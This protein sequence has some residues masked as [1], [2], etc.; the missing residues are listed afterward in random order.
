M[1]KVHLQKAAEA[2][3][4]NSFSIAIELYETALKEAPDCFGEWDAWGY[5]Q[6]LKQL[7]Q[8]E[9][10]LEVCR[11]YYTRHENFE[12]LRSL[13]AWCI[14]FTQISST[15]APA[16]TENR[17]KALQAINRLCPQGK[18]YS[19]APLAIFKW[20][21]N[22][23]AGPNIPWTEIKEWLD[24][25][26]PKLL[27]T[28]CYQMQGKGKLIELASELEEWYSWQSK[29]LLQLGKWEEGV[30]LCR[31]AKE[32]I[33]KWH[34][35]NHVWFDRREA[36]ALS[37]SGK[38]DDAKKLL[39]KALAQKRE[40]FMLADMAEL[41][42]DNSLK[43][44]FYGAACRA[45]GEWKSKVGLLL[46]IAQWLAQKGEPKA[47]ELHAQA[48]NCIR[49]KEGWPLS[50]SVLLLAGENWVPEQD[51]SKT[52][53]AILEKLKEIW[54]TWEVAA[55]ML[56]GKIREILPNGKA[57]FIAEGKRTFYFQLKNCQMPGHE[58][59][60]GRNVKFELV[61]GFDKK[62]NIISKNATNIRKA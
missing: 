54:Q 29:C 33:Q 51:T 38:K 3:K 14:Y 11:K 60:V 56:E 20:V 31:E 18:P 47:A 62:K 57:E 15:E 37:K 9:K 17:R 26:D 30:A 7:K 59:T 61:D 52:L 41:E 24:K 55:S 39:S 58:I 5:G 36:F 44:H 16:S 19:P 50:D 34:Y 21:K 53:L 49:Q 13:Y 32:K 23:A 40:W 43:K 48:C 6:C 1:V 8:Y 45:E 25:L 4:N 35:S 2:R 28:D 10:A 27:Q 22:L 46:K 42:Q 12:P